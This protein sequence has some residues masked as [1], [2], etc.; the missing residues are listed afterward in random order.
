MDKTALTAEVTHLFLIAGYKVD[1]S[2]RI[3]HREIDV[4]RGETQ[5][6]IRK[7]ILV[8]CA[9]YAASVGVQKMQDDISKLKAAR[10]DLLE[11]AI[12]MHVSRNGYSPDAS[13]YALSQ[14]VAIFTISTLTHQLVNFQSYIQAVENDRARDIILNEYQ[15][16]KL[17]FDGRSHRHARPALD[18]LNDW[19]RGPSRWLTILGDYGVGK[20]WMLK[21]YLFLGLE[22]HKK[23]K[24]YLFTANQPPS[25][26]P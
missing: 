19:V 7:I 4:R 20:S 10:D 14:G 5:G 21:R 12:L 22:Q 26:T 25:P 15:P 6:L 2:V 9:D 16:T 17:H 24:N 11:S 13:G 3:N 8:E 1:T 23:E 18:F